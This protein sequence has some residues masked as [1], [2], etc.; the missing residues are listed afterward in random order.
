M[1]VV[2]RRSSCTFSCNRLQR[3]SI[4]IEYASEMSRGGPTNISSLSQIFALQLE[5]AFFRCSLMSPLRTVSHPMGGR[6]LLI[7]IVP[8]NMR[9][10]ECGLIRL[11]SIAKLWQWM[12][13]QTCYRSSQNDYIRNTVLYIGPSYLIWRRAPNT[14]G[15]E[16]P[17]LIP[18]TYG[19]EPPTGDG[20][21]A[22]YT[23]CTHMIT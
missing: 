1:V 7:I 2:V 4:A 17:I 5:F 19:G 8:V 23:G 18:N 14:F 21:G 13:K 11:G 6:G 20:S 22:P 16:P 15:G 12:K 3:T 10:T 9:E